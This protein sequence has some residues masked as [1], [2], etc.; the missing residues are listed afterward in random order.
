MGKKENYDSSNGC[1]K[2]PICHLKRGFSVRQAAEYLGC[3]ERLVETKIAEYYLPV[4]YI[5][6]K[7]VIDKTDLDAFFDALPV[8]RPQAK[9]YSSWRS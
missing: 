2:Q 5:N 7:R 8:E 6:S 9:C 3:S 1:R 4:R